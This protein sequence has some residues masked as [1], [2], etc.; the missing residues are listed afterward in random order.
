MN[1]PPERLSVAVEPGRER[2]R[3][4]VSGEIDMDDAAEAREDL[5]TA[6]DASPGG[7][8]ID[9][10]AVTFCDSSG[11][12]VLLDLNQ[13]AVEAGK[14][15]VL[16][17]LS[18]T[19]VRL[20][21]VTGTQ[22]VLTIQDQPA[23]DGPPPEDRRPEVAKGRTGPVC[24]TDF[25]IRTRRCGPTVHLAF[26]GELDDESRSALDG[27]RENLDGVDVVACDL[28]Q[29]TFLD[30]AGLRGLLAFAGRLDE[31]G[32]AFF[33]YNWQPQPR[34][35]LHLVDSAKPAVGRG[36]PTRMLRRLQCSA[37]TAR[38]AG[39]ARAQQDAPQAAERPTH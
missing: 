29:L 1:S 32:I 13:Q 30:V 27:V 21:D 36:G 31:H 20:L 7:L 8:D 34:S 3:V 37:A 12:H 19:V 2:T 23:S 25:R 5:A 15:L 16:S 38:A 14:T 9:L 26:A 39:A 17:A 11:L 10:A 18:R 24:P 28:E 35:L 33:A 6:L 22:G 4:R